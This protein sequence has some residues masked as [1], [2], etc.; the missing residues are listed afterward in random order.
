MTELTHV[1]PR[2]VQARFRPLQLAG[3]ALACATLGL[4]GCEKPADELSGR[5]AQL[6]LERLKAAPEHGF[7]AE[8]FHVQRIEQLLDSSHGG[9]KAEGARELR[10]ALIDYARAQHGLT[11]PRRA[12]PE[13]WGLK[14][15][16]YDAETSLQ[17][18]L[19]GGKLQ[20]WLDAQPPASPAYQALQ[21]GYVSYLKIQAGGGWPTVS[22]TPLK[23]GLQGPQVAAL[24]QRLAL[25]DAQLAGAPQDGPVDAGLVAAV[26]RFQAAHGLPANGGLDAATVEQLNVPAQDRAAQIRAS[27][28]RLRWLPRQEPATRIDV[29]IAAAE[30]DYFRDNT[31]VTHMLAAS[32]RPGDETPMLQSQV[33][34]IVLNPPWNVP[35]GIAQDEIIPKGEAYLQAKGFA[36]KDGRLVQQPGPDAALGQV[37]FDFANPYAVYLHDTPAKAAFASSQRAV[38]HGC[39]RLAQAV[40]FAKTLLANEPGWSAERVDAVLASGETTRVT[41]TRRTP[42]RLIYLT[43]FPANGRIA[44]R[45]DVYGWDSRLL[46]LLDH[47]PAPP[48]RGKHA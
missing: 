22:A 29:N 2:P 21:K 40:P 48:K 27:L 44:F 42:V 41:L 30:M 11:I 8:R 17:Q 25:E 20:D 5:N 18:A 1:N 7:S 23:P 13:N 32:G 9:D 4:A 46:Q 47:P 35:E 24:R 33:D 19:Q 28:E 34:G 26:Q 3:L 43:A 36:M 39:V 15:A 16:S 10:A 45:P 37:K 31:L 6:A 12:F 14:P 38:S